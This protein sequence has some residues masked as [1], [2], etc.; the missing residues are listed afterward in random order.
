[1]R[2]ERNEMMKKQIKHWYTN[3]TVRKERIHEEEII[4]NPIPAELRTP[5]TDEEKRKVDET[6]H[7]VCVGG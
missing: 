1:M 4:L 3:R 5:L 7:S 2:N 6:W